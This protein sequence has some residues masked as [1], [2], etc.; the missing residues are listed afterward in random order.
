M[1]LAVLVSGSGT[2][3]QCVIE[4]IKTEKL[5]QIEI[6][7]VVADRDCFGLERAEKAGIK[8]HQFKRNSKLS[9][10]IDRVISEKVDFIVLAGFLSILSE[11]F[12]QKW[13]KKIINIHPSLLPKFGGKGMYGEYVHKAVLEAKENQS[14]ATVHF[15]TN[16]IDEGEI[17]VQKSFP[18]DANDNVQDLQ[19]KVRSVEHQILIEAIQK[20]HA[21]FQ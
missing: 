18:V 9:E 17:I 5:T 2:N 10:N 4:A 11:E 3:L 13:N 8:T 1:K 15:V 12:T 16:E 14:G 7:Y 20:I 19:N 21:K 6:V